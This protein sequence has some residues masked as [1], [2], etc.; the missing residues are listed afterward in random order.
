MKLPEELTTVTP[1]S[2]YFAM[3]LF[4]SLPFIGFFM[5]MNYQ[6]TLDLSGSQ[7]AYTSLTV[8][9]PSP[10]P[11]KINGWKTYKNESIGFSFSYP[12]E[13]T[14]LYDQFDVF[15][16]NNLGNLVKDE[17]NSGNLLLQ[18]FDGKRRAKDNS[19]DFQLVIDSYRN[20]EHTSLDSYVKNPNK[21]W[22]N[23][24]S[25]QSFESLTV[26]GENAIKGQTITKY[27]VTPAVWIKHKGYIL[28]IFLGTPNSTKLNLFDQILST[29]KFNQ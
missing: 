4:I 1:L 17:S 25:N 8:I 21:L 24:N 10:T 12:K 14:F 29:F 23:Y 22:N 16:K 9:K 27:K 15:I 20:P 26:G 19:S 5:G 6:S 2:K 7:Q 13:L 11:E 3:I 28:T 18:N